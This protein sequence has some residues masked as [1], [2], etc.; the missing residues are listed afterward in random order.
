MTP[1]LLSPK[2]VSRILNCSLRT[3]YDKMAEMEHVKAGGLLRVSPDEL[4]RYVQAHTVRPKN[5]VAKSRMAST[6]FEV[7][8][9]L[10]RRG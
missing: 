9:E 4:D 3:A 2:D 6:L 7:R 1:A 5:E 10:R 8:K